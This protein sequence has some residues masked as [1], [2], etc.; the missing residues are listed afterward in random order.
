MRSMRPRFANYNVRTLQMFFVERHR[1]LAL[2]TFIPLTLTVVSGMTYRICRQWLHMEKKSVVWLMGIHQMSLFGLQN[3]YPL[4]V[5]LLL[6]AMATSGLG[7]MG[8]RN[9]AWFCCGLGNCPVRPSNNARSLHRFSTTVLLVPMLVTTLTGLLFALGRD[10]LAFNEATLSLLMQIHQGSWT[11][12][13]AFYVLL[14]GCGF[15]TVMASGVAMTELVQM[16][17][18]DA[19]RERY[20]ALNVLDSAFKFRST[21]GDH[22]DAESEAPSDFE[23]DH[24]V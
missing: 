9:A 1:M 2:A 12:S 23:V 13:P 15:L 3:I 7:M 22:T 16:K 8:F 21:T 17:C 18:G 4:L 5:G 24:D 14:N 11:G 6:L 10:A 19:E 20:H